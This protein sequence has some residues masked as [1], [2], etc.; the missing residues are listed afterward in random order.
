MDAIY[1]CK[2][3]SN[4]MWVEDL[5]RGVMPGI[6]PY[7]W[8]IDTSIGDWYYN[9]HWKY[10]GADWVILTLVDTVSKNGNL[11]INVVQRPDGSLDPEA[12]Q[13]LEDL[14]AWMAV[15]SEAIYETRPWLV[16]GEGPIRAKGGHFGEDF[17]YTAKD[18][19]FTMKKDGSAL[20]AA[21]LGLPTEDKLVIRSLSK[22][23]EVTGQVKNV[24]LLGCSDKLTWTHDANGLTVQ[25]PA[26]KPCKFAIVLKITGENLR[27]FQPEK[28]SHRRRRS[29]P[30]PRAMSP[31]KR[32]MPI[33][34]A[35]SIPKT[36]TASLISV[37]GT[38]PRIGLRG[39]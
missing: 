24:Q 4:G 9:K 16:H 28:R 11:L 13:V 34:T 3:V 19:R 17:R 37:F 2:Q 1:T 25:L 32:T 26:Q 21:T 30:T 33:C 10:R 29:H 27:G 8:Q 15:N 23:P 5:E 38:R 20:Y 14:T 7:P 12:I 18:I 6:R 31:W 39:R 36:E 35:I 22:L